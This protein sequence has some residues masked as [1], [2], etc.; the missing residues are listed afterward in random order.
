MFIP[1]PGMLCCNIVAVVPVGLHLPA[2]VHIN[3]ER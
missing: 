2:C 1:F 3:A